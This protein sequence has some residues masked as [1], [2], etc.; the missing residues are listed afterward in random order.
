[1]ISSRPLSPIQMLS[2]HAYLFSSDQ[3]PSRAARRRPW[4]GGRPCTLLGLLRHARACQLWQ[5]GGGLLL[6]GAQYSHGHPAPTALRCPWPF[7]GG[8]P[9]P[10]QTR[11]CAVL[12]ITQTRQVQSACIGGD[13]V[14]DQDT[15]SHCAWQSHLQCS[16]LLKCCSICTSTHA[17]VCSL[18]PSL[19]CFA[20]LYDSFIYL[21]VCCR[22]PLHS[23]HEGKRSDGGSAPVEETSWAEAAR[24]CLVSAGASVVSRRKATLDTTL[25]SACRYSLHNQHMVCMAV[26]PATPG[27]V[28]QGRAKQGSFCLHRALSA[29]LPNKH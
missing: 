16:R 7:K 2:C 8:P 29:A 20:L 15:A 18:T 6:L 9:C 12:S 5:C 28:P 11:C 21:F 14:L 4:L 24:S 22:S 1:M 25:P 13:H 23:A 17:W 26:L 19:P 27:A 10:P 3:G